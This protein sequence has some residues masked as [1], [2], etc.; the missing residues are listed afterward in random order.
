MH[1]NYT[2]LRLSK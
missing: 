1:T 2:I